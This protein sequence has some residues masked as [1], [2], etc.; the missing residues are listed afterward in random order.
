MYSYEW[1]SK[2]RGAA[3]GG[4]VPGSSLIQHLGIGVCIFREYLRPCSFS[5]PQLEGVTVE[6]V[7]QLHQS[8]WDH[9]SDAFSLGSMD[10]PVFHSRCFFLA[11]PPSSLLPR[12][13]K[14]RKVSKLSTDPSRWYNSFQL[15]R[16]R[17]GL[18]RIA[19]SWNAGR[20]S[21]YRFC[22]P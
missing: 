3:G 15:D 4:A 11:A 21:A 16:L 9:V 14:D 17:D 20:A 10:L 19:R 1:S 6:T 18:D 13:L 12:I 22:S 5:V 7:V 8:S 2:R